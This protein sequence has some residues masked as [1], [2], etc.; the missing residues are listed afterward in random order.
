VGDGWSCELLGCRVVV[1][2]LDTLPVLGGAVLLDLD[3]DFLVTPGTLL[4]EGFSADDPWL[5]PSDCIARLRRARLAPALATIAYS[6]EGG[7]TPLRWKYFGDELAARLLAAETSGFDWLREAHRLAGTGAIDAA[8]Q[9]CRDAAAA[10]PNPAAA[11]FALAHVLAQRGQI[12]AAC[13]AHLAA[14]AHDPPYATAFNC[15]GP[16]ALERGRVDAAE[17]A[18]MDQLTLDENDGHAVAG[19][20][21][22]A[23]RRR[24]WSRAEAHARGAIACGLDAPDVYRVLARALQHQGRIGEA[25][26]ALQRSLR[27]TLDGHAPRCAIASR[28]L[29]RLPVWDAEHGR[30]Y[31]TLA[32]LEARLGRIRDA[33]AAL[34]LAIASGYRRPAVHARL[35]GLY[36]RQH[37]WGAALGEAAAACA[38]APSSF[39]RAQRHARAALEHR[40]EA[41]RA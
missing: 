4:G 24:Q 37:R 11:E 14:R 20:A 41:L 32:A 19:L 21:Q 3:V 1:C 17:R 35:A 23:M 27:V 29:S 36:A 6:V 10:L 40:L 13:A 9:A 25:V 26:T 30:A 16:V 7:Y 5:W 18:F 2:D 8:A 34:Q 12:E 38:A 31:V 33:I 22:V 28:R 15:A 39:A